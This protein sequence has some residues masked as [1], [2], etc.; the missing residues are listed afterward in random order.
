M[1]A[2]EAM[3]YGRP[4]VATAVGGVR[5][6]VDDE[7]GRLVPPRDVDALRSTLVALLAAPEI[8]S[9]LGEAGRARVAARLGRDA[10]AGV[11]LRA[12]AQASG[13]PMPGESQ[14]AAAES[15]RGGRATDPGE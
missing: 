5:D 11:L 9:G 4:V 12:Y 6:V 8:R 2:R 15:P 3:A 10:A 1:V 14:S 7:V 13:E